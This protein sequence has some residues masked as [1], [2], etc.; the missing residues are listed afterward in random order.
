M[1]ARRVGAKLG[2]AH[3]NLDSFGPKTAIFRQNNPQIR[4]KRP[5]VGKQ[6]PH[7]TC[8]LTSP[9]QR[10]LPCPS[11][12]LYVRET[13]Q[14][15]A[16][17][18]QTLRNVHQHPQTKQGPYS[19]LPGSKSDSE[20]TKSTRNP[21]L[22][23]VSKPQNRAKRRLDPRTSGD[24]EEPEGSSPRARWGPTVGPPRSPGRKKSSFQCCSQTTWDAQS[25]VFSPFPARDD[26]FLVMEN[27]KMP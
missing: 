1:A 4:A 24:L 22:F 12:P 17:N 11:T 21:P 15:G 8:G 16:T 7:Y 14:K 25:S 6:C 5:N 2:G 26:A 10:A 20:G 23:V 9:C 3:P 13:A 27:S 18:P 19:G